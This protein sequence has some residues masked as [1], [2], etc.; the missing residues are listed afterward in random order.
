M[1]WY[2]LDLLEGEAQDEDLDAMWR[3]AWKVI[4]A[5]RALDF[6][7]AVFRRSGDDPVIFFSPGAREL[8]ETFTAK[9]CEQPTAERLH[10]VAGD[11]RAWKIFFPDSAPPASSDCGS[12]A[13]PSKYDAP[14][15]RTQPSMLDELFYPTSPSQLG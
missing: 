8:A 1:S 9:R 11:D 10:L 13:V 2:I 6:R 5:E 15:V 14:F 12:L 3:A 4:Y 7:N